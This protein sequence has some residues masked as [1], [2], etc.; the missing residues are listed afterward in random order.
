[1]YLLR[2]RRCPR[3]WVLIRHNTSPKASSGGRAL[4]KPST[5]TRVVVKQSRTCASVPLEQCRGT[6]LLTCAPRTRAETG[7]RDNGRVLMATADRSLFRRTHAPGLPD[8]TRGDV[9]YIQGAQWGSGARPRPRPSQGEDNV[10]AAA[11]PPVH[12]KDQRCIDVR[13]STNIVSASPSGGTEIYPETR[14]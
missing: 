8:T 6:M 2:G 10:E 11:Q 3:V 13:Y 1:M 9:L 14:R 12:V 5:M 7:R 4:D